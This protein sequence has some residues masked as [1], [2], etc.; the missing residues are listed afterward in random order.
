[1]QHF[2]GTYE[3]K[4]DA[5]GRIMLPAALKNNFRTILIKVLL[6]KGQFSIPVW[7]CIL[8]INGMN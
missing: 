3:C 5:K 6:S 8:W 7:N 4:A 1:M 2:I